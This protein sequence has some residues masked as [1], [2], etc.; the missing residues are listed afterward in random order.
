MSIERLRDLCKSARGLAWME[1][2]LAI[3]DH[4][5]ATNGH[6]L[7]A[8]PISG[9]GAVDHPLAEDILSDPDRPP[10]MSLTLGELRAWAGEMWREPCDCTLCE[11]CEG[12]GSEVC[13]SCDSFIT[14]RTC[15][16]VTCKQCGSRGIDDEPELGMVG[17]TGVD[18]RLFATGLRCIDGDGDDAAK[19]WYTDGLG[20]IR[21]RVGEQ[22]L[23]CMPFSLRFEDERARAER[24]KLGA[25]P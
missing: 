3:G 25:Q 6:C 22:L 23:V 15:E 8:L 4:T 12:T 1:S 18:C 10:D 21:V 2:L 5:A 13:P 24:R 16:G 20:A 9:E 11:T 17:E 7:V 14:C 19:L